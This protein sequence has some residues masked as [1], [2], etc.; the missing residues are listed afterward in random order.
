M[1]GGVKRRLWFGGCCYCGRWHS[2]FGLGLITSVWHPD[3]NAP[4]S[5]MKPY[6]RYCVEC[7]KVRHPGSYTISMQAVFTMVDRIPWV[8]TESEAKWW[9]LWNIDRAFSRRA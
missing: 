3:I 7:E 2:K 1:V 8:P 6:H 9:A 4:Y 5:E